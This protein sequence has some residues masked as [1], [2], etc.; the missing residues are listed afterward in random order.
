MPDDVFDDEAVENSE[1][2]N[3]DCEIDWEWDERDTGYEGD[4]W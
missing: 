3:E 1:Q 2:E 4:R